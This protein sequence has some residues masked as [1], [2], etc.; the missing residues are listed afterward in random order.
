M[1]GLSFLLGVGRCLILAWMVH[2]PNCVHSAPPRTDLNAELFT[3]IRDGDRI[4]VKALLRRGAGVNERDEDAATALMHA[5]AD[6]DLPTMKL[7][8][9]EGADINA[10]SKSGATA[11]LW[12]LHDV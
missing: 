5:A 12:T 11:L 3:A 2:E 6:G 1:R 8:L 4:S 9:E 10:T 7:L